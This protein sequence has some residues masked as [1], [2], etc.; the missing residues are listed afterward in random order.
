MKQLWA[1][2]RLEYIVGPKEG[3]CFL[4]RM[5]RE[6]KDRE[7]LVLR[8]GAT[9]AIVMNRFPYSNGHLMVCPNR[10]IA[11]LTDLTREERAEMMDRITQSIEALRK[12]VHPH[13][14]NVGANLGKVA[15]AGLEAH[16]HMHIVPRWE[17][18]TNFMPVLGQTKVIPQCCYELWDQLQPLLND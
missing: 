2:W 8:R 11:D 3:E 17:S 15:G 18:D 14:F 5:L 4:C 6:D 13:G 10:H 16:L 12:T 9:C 1:P 7:N